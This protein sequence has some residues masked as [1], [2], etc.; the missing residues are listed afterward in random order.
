MSAT[1]TSTRPSRRELH[2]DLRAAYQ[3]LVRERAE[4]EEA[5]ATP[6]GRRRRREPSSGAL[7]IARYAVWAAENGAS[8]VAAQR[9]A[10]SGSWVH[11]K[12]AAGLRACGT[13]PLTLSPAE[14]RRHLRQALA[15]TGHARSGCLSLEDY[16][17]YAQEVPDAPSPYLIARALGVSGWA[18]AMR[19]AGASARWE[20][21]HPESPEGREE[22]LAPLRELADQLGHVPSSREYDRRRAR[23]GAASSAYISAQFHGWNAAIVAAGLTPAHKSRPQRQSA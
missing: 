13:P 3:A 2:A 11:A 17:A 12:R 10:H 16:Y 5:P 7:T 23:P 14:A 15:V 9:A 6:T 20:R 18:A 4:G 1:S 21:H 22:L 8:S 19:E